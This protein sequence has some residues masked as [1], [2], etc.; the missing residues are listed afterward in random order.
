MTCPLLEFLTYMVTIG[1]FDN[2]LPLF[3]SASFQ[4]KKVEKHETVD[5]KKIY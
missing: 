3:I 1:P 4:C 2:F 5:T